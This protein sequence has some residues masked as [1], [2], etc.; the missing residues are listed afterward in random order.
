MEEASRGADREAQ[1]RDEPAVLAA[2]DKVVR[3]VRFN[4]LA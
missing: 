4:K 2:P 3:G 1:A